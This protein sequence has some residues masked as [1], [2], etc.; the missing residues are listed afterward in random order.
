MDILPGGSLLN[1]VI[2]G[3]YEGRSSGG[4]ERKSVMDVLKVGESYHDMKRKAEG[5]VVWP[6]INQLNWICRQT[7]HQKIIR[8]RERVSLST[9]PW[10]AFLYI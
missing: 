10:T 7:E 1:D 2:E 4:R 6:E 3:R 5:T 8:E 9:M